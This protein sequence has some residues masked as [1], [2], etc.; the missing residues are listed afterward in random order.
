MKRFF[1]LMLAGVLLLSACGAE[2]GIEVHEAWMRP[3][4]QGENGAVYF[5]IHNHA[6]RADELIGVTADV[7]AA[8]EMHESK[9]TGDVMQMNEVV[10]VSLEAYAEVEFR[11]GRLHV[12]L[13]DLRR[14]LRT[15]DEVELA[16][17]F[18]HFEEIKVTA[19]V[20]ESAPPEADHSA[21]EH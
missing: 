20:G 3:A 7:A 11:P 9:M 15:G 2:K 21:E 17:H 4:A 5:V 16:L 19:V 12:M 1:V 14:D 8:V 18:T 13:I 10:S 6:S